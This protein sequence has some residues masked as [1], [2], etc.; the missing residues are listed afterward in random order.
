[1]QFPYDSNS[2]L[3]Y[4]DPIDQ[5]MIRKGSTVQTIYNRVNNQAMIQPTVAAQPTYSLTAMNGLP[6]WVFDGTSQ[7]I[8]LSLPKVAISKPKPLTLAYALAN[9]SNFNFGFN[10]GSATLPNPQIFLGFVP[11]SLDAVDNVDVVIQD[12]T[13]ANDAAYATIAV[14]SNT[15]IVSAI[16]DTTQLTLRFDGKVVATAP[17]S[18]TAGNSIT[19]D[20]LALGD[21]SDG[22]VGGT[23]HFY[24]AGS[25]GKVIIEQGD[26]A[27]LAGEKY[28]LDYYS[29]PV[30]Y[31]VQF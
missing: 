12:D 4:L 9:G 14:D 25:I 17:I 27:N 5:Y 11:T 28:L 29:I 1:M 24:F 10:I 19:L 31:D 13:G 2:I 7:R 21:V 8:T 26:V 18:S 15:H 3:A 6:G 23:G 20:Q 22:S 30:N 16:I